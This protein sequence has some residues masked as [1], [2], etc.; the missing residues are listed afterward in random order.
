MC[1]K[2]IESQRYII[3][4]SLTM[5]ALTIPFKDYYEA[6]GVSRDVTEAHLKKAYRKV[7]ALL[8]D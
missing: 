7:S 1:H 3:D 5:S 4:W 8:S 6:L 2:G